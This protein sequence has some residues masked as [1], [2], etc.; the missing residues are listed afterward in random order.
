ML[1]GQKLTR[2]IVNAINGKKTDFAQF[3]V[4]RNGSHEQREQ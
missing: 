4:A 2:Q 3:R 1:N